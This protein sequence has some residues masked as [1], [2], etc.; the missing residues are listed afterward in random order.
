MILK[1]SKS[2]VYILLVIITFII[3]TS[4]IVFNINVKQNEVIEFN[5]TSIT[6]IIFIAVSVGILL[7]IRKINYKLSN[8]IKTGLI[9]IRICNLY[10]CQYFFYKQI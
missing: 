1:L 2:V 5:I 4:T 9:I 7:L 3:L 10:N 8:K 6:N